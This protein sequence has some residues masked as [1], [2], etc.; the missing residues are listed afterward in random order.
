MDTTV[1]PPI[2]RGD[3]LRI[4]FL[5]PDHLG[6]I[7]LTFPAVCALRAALPG[8]RIGFLVPEGLENAAWL[9]GAV[10]SVH[11][12]RFP[13]LAEP[14]DK[15]TW[16][17]RASRIGSALR[18]RYDVALLPRPDDPWCGPIAVSAGIPCRLGF[19][20]ENMGPYVSNPVNLPPD[21]HVSRLAL[22]LVSA[23]LGD[24]HLRDADLVSLPP[25]SIRVRDEDKDRA[26]SLL[27][28]V[29]GRTGWRPI[30]IH[31]GSGWPIK[32]WPPERWAAVAEAIHRRFGV[33][34][35]AL[36]TPRDIE[37]MD[38]VSRAGAG[39]VC[40]LPGQ[41]S[42]GTLAALHRRAL[43]VISSD[44]GALHLAALVGTPIIGLYGPADPLQFGPLLPSARVGIVR[45][46]LP[47]SPCRT[48]LDPPCGFSTEPPC[49]VGIAV[50]R[51]LDAVDGVLRGLSSQSPR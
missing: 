44:S 41:V 19:D 51:V 42:V 1:I 13:N 10:D 11:W 35:L 48:L 29:A 23:L 22:A 26:R 17:E 47:C 9:C 16:A 8:V 50:D 28:Q 38:A 34:V 2:G 31:A 46:G 43:L 33:H 20:I 3:D 36:G 14:F 40:Q 24:S 4:L 18:G 39:A 32:N 45:V 5:R 7:L 15:T 49:M 21:G 12:M 25:A 30:I 27:A 6:D 37:L